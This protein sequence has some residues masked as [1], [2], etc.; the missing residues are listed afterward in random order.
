LD[1]SKKD[2][3][4]TNSRR[5]KGLGEG[6]KA[7]NNGDLPVGCTDND[8]WQKW[9][10]TTYIWWVASLDDVW[11]INCIDA[12]N[13]LQI[14]WDTIF[15]NALHYVVSVSRC[16]VFSVVCSLI[17]F[18]P[19][20]TFVLQ[21]HQRLSDSWR[22]YIASAAVAILISIFECVD[23]SGM[24]ETDDDR[25]QFAVEMLDDQRFLYSKYED[26]GKVC[27]CNCLLLVQIESVSM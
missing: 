19:L 7:F 21:A 5:K 12:R 9:F 2:R 27:V 23:N 17:I 10:I 16:P 26:D 25:Q 11:S 14:L 20:V 24:F 4:A 3:V 8:R 18:L 13:A 1:V 6:K 22:A 15:G